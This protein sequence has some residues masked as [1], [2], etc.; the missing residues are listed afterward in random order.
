MGSKAASVLFNVLRTSSGPLN[1]NAQWVKR[2]N[3][4]PAKP[5]ILPGHL[6]NLV[7]AAETNVGSIAVA[8]LH[9]LVLSKGRHC[10]PF[11][12]VGNYSSMQWVLN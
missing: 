1:S 7:V 12:V 2:L 10:L 4:G 9:R 5:R 3:L 11:R 8:D 6:H